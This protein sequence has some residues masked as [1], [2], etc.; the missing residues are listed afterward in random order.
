MLY[1]TL[2]MQTVRKYYCVGCP[3]PTTHT[4]THT[5]TQMLKAGAVP[6]EF[7]ISTPS[8]GIPLRWEIWRDDP[9]CVLLAVPAGTV[10]EP[11]N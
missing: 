7:D 5:H 10:A 1:G 8:W 11:A 4:H 3:H 9:V 6:E 2:S